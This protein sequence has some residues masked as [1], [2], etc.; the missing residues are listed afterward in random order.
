[1]SKSE[2]ELEDDDVDEDDECIEV[3][4]V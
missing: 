1:V 3:G 2:D 4:G